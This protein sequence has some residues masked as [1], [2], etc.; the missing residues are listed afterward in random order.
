MISYDEILKKI[1][2]KSINSYLLESVGEFEI[3]R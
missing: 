3:D 1:K 2:K